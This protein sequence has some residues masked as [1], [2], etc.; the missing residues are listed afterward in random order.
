VAG[1]QS[2]VIEREGTTTEQRASDHM[3]AAI[4][5]ELPR[6]ADQE[7]ESGATPDYGGGNRGPS[8][9]PNPLQDAIDGMNDS[10]RSAIYRKKDGAY[11]PAARRK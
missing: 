7:D 5:G 4:R 6:S 10:I 1:R 8:S 11:R 3:N 2:T 9:P